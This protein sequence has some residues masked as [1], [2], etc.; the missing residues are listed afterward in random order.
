MEEEQLEA[1]NSSEHDS[2]NRDAEALSDDL[3]GG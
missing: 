2:E 1:Y 3:A